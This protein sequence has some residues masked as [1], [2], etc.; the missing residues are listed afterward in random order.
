MREEKEREEREKR[1]GGDI[2]AGSRDPDLHTP[3]RG[4]AR[5]EQI[6]NSNYCATSA[7]SYWL[8]SVMV[9][10]SS[11]PKTLRFIPI[12]VDDGDMTTTLSL[13]RRLLSFQPSNQSSM[14]SRPGGWNG[15][16][17]L[18]HSSTVQYPR[19]LC[20]LPFK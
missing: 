16:L 14:G 15:V 5:Y 20:E 13:P 6:P 11:G 10:N 9:R 2:E 12:T 8:T 19:P 3:S 18:L 17:R 1:G 4:D 7:F